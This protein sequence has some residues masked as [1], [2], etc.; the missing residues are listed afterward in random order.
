MTTIRVY[1]PAPPE[2]EAAPFA[3]APRTVPDGARLLVVDNAKPRARDLL[4]RL[5]DRAAHHLGV[6][7]VEVHTKPSAGA[8]LDADVTRMLA[9]RSH[10][11][12]S[13]LGD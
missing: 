11:V 2:P 13:G 1:R 12:I 6:A 3:P 4:T 7:E 9:V 5:A 10:L 8:P